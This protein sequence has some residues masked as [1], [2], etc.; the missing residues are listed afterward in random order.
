MPIGDPTPSANTIG[1]QMGMNLAGS[2]GFT[3]D[4]VPL[5]YD[6]ASSIPSAAATTGWNINRVSNT[7]VGGGRGGRAQNARGF[8]QT[9]SPGS[10]RRLARAANIDPTHWNA[11]GTNKVY[12]PF[13]I[14]SSAGNWA[15]KPRKRVS[16]GNNLAT[17]MG[18]QDGV[19]PF[20]PGT[21]GRIATGGRISSMSASQLS[22]SQGHI[23]NSIKDINPDYFDNVLRPVMDK[24]FVFGASEAKTVGTLRGGVTGT[25]TGSV[26]G[27]VAGFVGSAETFGTT[28]HSGFMSALPK[29]SAARVGAQAGSRFM[30]ERGGG[31]AGRALAS[32][33]VSGAA[34]AAGPIG[35]ML[36]AKDVAT[37]GGKLAGAGINLTTDAGRSMMGSLSK[38]VMGMGYKDNTI[39]ATSRQRGV[40]AISNSRLNMRSALG[41]EAA[42]VH[43]S[44]G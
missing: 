15:A 35:W 9:L 38:P 44:F 27:R 4:D 43:A 1:G 8:R 23:L 25:V 22:R 10:Q 14:L 6:M 31:L 18:A 21:V 28:A 42:F 19:A 32:G 26:S 36:L 7:I 13:N 17:R 12:S 3:N 30:A 37:M 39:A 40:Q 24:Q 2:A 34:R 5:F 33:A 29:E 20:S 16:I 41:S 11:G